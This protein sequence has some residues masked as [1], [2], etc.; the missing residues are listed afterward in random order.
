MKSPQITTDG[1]EPRTRLK[2]YQEDIMKNIGDAV[3]CKRAWAYVHRSAGKSIKGEIRMELY[4]NTLLTFTILKNGG[5]SGKHFINTVQG[6]IDAV[7]NDTHNTDS[8]E[9]YQ[10]PTEFDE[11]GE[12]VAWKDTFYDMSIEEQLSACIKRDNERY[13]SFTTW[14]IADEKTI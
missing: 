14:S 1:S 9:E 7:Y 10:E 12:A 4:Q 5:A 8:F 6:Y 3:Q 2:L 11:D 13:A